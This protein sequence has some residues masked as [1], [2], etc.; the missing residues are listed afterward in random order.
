MQSRDS[1][2]PM[3][4]SGGTPLSRL[5]RGLLHALSSSARF[6]AAAHKDLANHMLMRAEQQDGRGSRSNLENSRPPTG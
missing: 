1:V 3:D 2:Q 4:V 5:L 6:G